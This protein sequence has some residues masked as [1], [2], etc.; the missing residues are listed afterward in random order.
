MYSTT[1][2]LTVRQLIQQT[3]KTTTDESFERPFGCWAT[4]QKSEY[5][6][7]ILNGYALT[8][9]VLADV[10]SCQ[11][12][13]DRIDVS[14]G[15][16]EVYFRQLANEGWRYVSVDGKHRRQ[17]IHNFYNNKLGF[18]GTMVSH[19]GARRK[20]NNM[21]FKEMPRDF[22]DHFL[23]SQIVVQEVRDTT[24]P[25]LS[26]LFRCINKSTQVTAQHLRNSLGTSFAREMRELTKNYEGFV[27]DF[28]KSKQ[29]AEMKPHEELSKAY[30]HI[31]KPGV[32]FDNRMSKGSLNELYE[33][34]IEC[35]ANAKFG[36]CY[37]QK[38]LNKINNMLELM[39]QITKK[40]LSET[41]ISFLLLMLVIEKVYDANLVIGDYDTF[42]QEIYKTDV[43]LTTE[44]R[45]QQTDDRDN[46]VTE[47]DT[48]D[49]NYYY[50]WRRLNWNC[51]TA[52]QR[53]LWDEISKNLSC[54][55]LRDPAKKAA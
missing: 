24:R 15:T 3:A 7:S 25:Q 1:N 35:G 17:V 53:V 44:S 19:S 20:V 49:R 42:L 50:E 37:E 27:K 43:L 22:Q 54:Y 33:R 8:P 5:I 47:L 46:G 21:L 18:T 2:P 10:V 39:S 13:S 45:K 26:K 9:M 40:Q 36:D 31:N 23:N 52:R 12:Y 38:H 34:G 51:R 55:G 48:P 16:S 6:Q 41:N 11:Q 28:F 14:D 32:E 30:L 4:T 29:I